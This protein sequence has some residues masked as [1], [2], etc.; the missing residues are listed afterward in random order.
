[1]CGHTGR[2]AEIGMREIGEPRDLDMRAG[3]VCRSSIYMWLQRCLSCGYCAPDIASGV[4]AAR[5]VVGGE[6]YKR[7]LGD[8]RFPDTVNAFLCW[9][10]VLEAGGRYDEAA[11][12]VIYA[13][14][15][16]DD[17]AEHRSWA[18]HF[19]KKALAT[20]DVAHGKNQLLTDDLTGDH[21]LMVDLLRRAGSFKAA[22]RLCARELEKN[23]DE[24]TIDILSFQQELIDTKDKR[25]HA[26]EEA[27]DDGD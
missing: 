19:R 3:G 13:A 20:I 18:S 5:T 26:I 9:A 11:W 14:W 1:V 21:L 22:S 24:R 27:L 15:V 12:A 2:Q 8:S 17:D 6:A 25:R 4:E 16:C 10:M 7:Q 23:H